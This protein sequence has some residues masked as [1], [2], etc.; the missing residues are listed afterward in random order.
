MEATED[1][2]QQTVWLSAKTGEGLGFLKV[3]IA[4]S[5]GTDRIMAWYRLPANHSR[6]ISR[7][8]AQSAI[9]E[10]KYGEDG[11]CELLISINR[12]DWQRILGAEGLSEESLTPLVG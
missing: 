3:A 12:P 7:L 1:D 10:E 4:K 5:L 11:S 8:H 6:L 2:S 9:Q